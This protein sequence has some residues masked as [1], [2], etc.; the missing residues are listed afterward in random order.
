[1]G[2]GFQFVEYMAPNGVCVKLEVDDFYDDKVRNN[3]N[4]AFDVINNM[5]EEKL[6]DCINGM[7]TMSMIG[8][9]K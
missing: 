9:M 1:M 5:D 7:M 4:K 2:A 6:Q 3:V 8:L